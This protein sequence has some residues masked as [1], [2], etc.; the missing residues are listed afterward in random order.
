[1]PISCQNERN[2]YLR[3]E[4][5]LEL[6]AWDDSNFIRCAYVTILG[7]QPDEQ[8]EDYY[9]ALLRT[10][11]SKLHILR[12]F[13][14]SREGTDH[15][16]GIAGLDRALRKAHREQIPLLGALVRL[17]TGGERDGIAFQRHRA[18]MNEVARARIAQQGTQVELEAAI[19]AQKELAGLMT[20]YENMLLETR[21]EH[22]EFA[23]GVWQ[24]LSNS[25]KMILE[26]RKDIA[27]ASTTQSALA[28]NV[29]RFMANFE[30]ALKPRPED[31]MAAETRL[32]PKAQKLYNS[33]VSR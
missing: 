19:Q 8:G 2:P 18:L 25:E 20:S 24:V 27:G 16:P 33:L 32:T 29:L 9:T 14:R 13:R 3:A 31:R 1:M 15:D 30:D 22:K 17:F 10:G 6:L 12:Q 23:G 4:S 21:N 5:L 7:R 28:E 11:R 26:V